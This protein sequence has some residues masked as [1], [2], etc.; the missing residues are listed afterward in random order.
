[1]KKNRATR[2]A[3]T[4]KFIT[5]C[6]QSLIRLIK[7]EASMIESTWPKVYEAFNKKAEQ[8]LTN[9]IYKDRKGYIIL[10]INNVRD[11]LH[12]RIEAEKEMKNGQRNC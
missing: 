5:D 11:A 6:E 9:P 2:K 4:D 8:L 12:K 3:E 1:M 7:Q 10:A